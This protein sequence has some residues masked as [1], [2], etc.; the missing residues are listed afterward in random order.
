MPLGQKQSVE[1]LNFLLYSRAL[2]P[3]LFEIYHDQ[4][5]VQPMF[6]ATIWITGCSHVITFS[7][8]AG[9]LSEV[10][11]EEQDI[12]PERGLVACFRVRG[13]KQ[14]EFRNPQGAKYMMNLQVESMSPKLYTQTHHDLARSAAKQ[15]LFVPFPQWRANELTPF[16]YIDY[17]S[18]PE[19]L[20]IFAFHA[21]PDVLTVVKTQ[22]IYEMPKAP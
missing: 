17:Q 12:L 6:D 20:H 22:S 1:T 15:G 8:L 16:T 18:T 19:A 13:E 2:H 10:M 5:I 21:F 4:K 14:H 9:T 7:S 3:E 11:A